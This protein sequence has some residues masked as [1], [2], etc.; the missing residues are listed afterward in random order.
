LL[1]H[2]V[3][4]CSGMSTSAVKPCSVHADTNLHDLARVLIREKLTE[5]PVID[6]T[7]VLIGQVNMYEITKAYRQL[8]LKY[9]NLMV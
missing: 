2:R 3:R 4:T 8:R 5:I 6:E 9:A 7:N 1:R